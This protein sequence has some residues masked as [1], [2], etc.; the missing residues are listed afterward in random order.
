[1]V[2]EFDENFVSASS[3]D[4][5]IDG[6]NAANFVASSDWGRDWD[7]EKYA[8]VAGLNGKSRQSCVAKVEVAPEEADY[9]FDKEYD[10]TVEGRIYDSW[11]S[12]NFVQTQS[13]D[14]VITVPA[15]DFTFKEPD[16]VVKDVQIA[17]TESFS[18]KNELN[19]SGK[20]T[21][22]FETGFE[23]N[24]YD[25]TANDSFGFWWTLDAPTEAIP[26]GSIVYQYVSFIKSGSTSKFTTVGCATTVGDPYVAQ[27]DT[28]N[29]T[30][31]M[32]ATSTVVAG[33]TWTE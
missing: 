16:F 32:A 15:A 6:Q 13:Y 9:F 11:T 27:I 18:Y 8:L 1:M 29:G 31:S 4:A 14:Y 26:D 30:S 10:V 19:V 17:A 25:D 21:Q 7:M 28:F 22:W 5:T 12:E 24:P 2:L 23:V 20:A 3:G 33:K